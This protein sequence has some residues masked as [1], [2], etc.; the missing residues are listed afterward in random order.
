MTTSGYVSVWLFCARFLYEIQE[1][2]CILLLHFISIIYFIHFD[3]LLFT[4]SQLKN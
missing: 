3:Q 4:L 2:L 1:Q